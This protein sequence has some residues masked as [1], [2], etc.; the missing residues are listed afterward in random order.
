[1]KGKQIV[2]A[3]ALSLFCGW[4][5]AGQGW[6]VTIQN[7]TNNALTM[8][9]AGSTCWYWNDIHDSNVISAKSSVRY[10][11]EADNSGSCSGPS[12]LLELI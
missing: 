5:L 10:Y 1:M 6:F 2:L 12:H 4:V 3:L 11:T 9:R 7:N 8:Q